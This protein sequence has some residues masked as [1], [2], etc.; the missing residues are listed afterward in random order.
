LDESELDWD[1]CGMFL[2]CIKKS[3][4]PSMNPVE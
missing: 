3:F 1:A 2:L 4:H